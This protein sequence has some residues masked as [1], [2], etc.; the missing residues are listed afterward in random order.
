MSDQPSTSPSFSRYPSCA[1]S[2]RSVPALQLL[3]VPIETSSSMLGT[4]RFLMSSRGGS[5]SKPFAKHQRVAS[6]PHNPFVSSAAVD[7]KSVQSSLSAWHVVPPRF[8]AVRK[9]HHLLS[10]RRSVIVTVDLVLTASTCAFVPVFDVSAISIGDFSIDTADRWRLAN[11]PYMNTRRPECKHW[12]S[13]SAPGRSSFVSDTAGNSLIMEYKQGEE[14]LPFMSVFAYVSQFP[15]RLDSQRFRFGLLLSGRAFKVRQG[16]KVSLTTAGGW[17]MCWFHLGGL[18]AISYRST[19]RFTDS[20]FARMYGK[21]EYRSRLSVMVHHY[22]RCL[23]IVVLTNDEGETSIEL[24]CIDLPFDKACFI[25]RVQQWLADSDLGGEAR[26]THCDPSHRV[27]IGLH[28]LEL[29]AAC[30]RYRAILY[31]GV[32]FFNW[33]S[34]L[35]HRLLDVPTPLVLA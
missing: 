16:D 4:K 5:A 26:Q 13:V 6:Y 17:L 12:S 7:G 2:I 11:T 35:S 20:P 8:S 14:F 25:L 31:A 28:N 30:P 33:S 22:F 15:D 32:A 23:D 9:L 3:L 21:A 18:G 27:V 10:L 34:Y 29:F 24:C 1:L 19:S